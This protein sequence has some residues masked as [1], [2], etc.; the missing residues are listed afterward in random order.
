MSSKWIGATLAALAA[1][2][3][4]DA[5][6]APLPAP[7]G[8]DASAMPVAPSCRGLR[9]PFFL[10]IVR[11]EGIDYSASF[12][13]SDAGGRCALGRMTGPGGAQGPVVARAVGVEP[14][15]L[16]TDW[17]TALESETS[18]GVDGAVVQCRTELVV[19]VLGQDY[20]L[21]SP[22]AEGPLGEAFRYVRS[23]IREGAPLTDE[24]R[25]LIASGDWP[26][27]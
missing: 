3:G 8:A 23:T 20:E 27:L 1:L 6:E 19:R 11:R 22:D 5:T 14:G 10:L 21:E 15:V 4:C 2:V 25:A 18:C 13:D 9:P 16:R 26:L 17:P 24:S 7:S 12:H